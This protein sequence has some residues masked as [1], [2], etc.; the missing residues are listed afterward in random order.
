MAP[1]KDLHEHLL[2]I[3]RRLPSDFEPYGDRERHLGE[4]DCS[5]GCRHYL[6]FAPPLGYDWGV[7]TNRESPRVGLLTFEHQG[8]PAFEFGE[9]DPEYLR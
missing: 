9:D 3:V 1:S 7:C 2:E 5:C 4:Q 8:C 6:T